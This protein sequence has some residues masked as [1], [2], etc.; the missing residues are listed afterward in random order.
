MAFDALN[1]G[2]PV[3]TKRMAEYLGITERAALKRLRN[4][5]FENEKTPGTWNE[6]DPK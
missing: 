4:A 6:G 1:D 5:G 2:T 3:T